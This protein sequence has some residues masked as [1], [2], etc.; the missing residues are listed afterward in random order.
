M[1]KINS[2]VFLTIIALPVLDIMTTFTTSLPLSVGAVVRTIG[3]GILF[4]YLFL[5]F[6]HRDSTFYFS[7]YLAAFM[8]ITLSFLINFVMKNPFLLIDEIQFSL[9]TVYYIIMI[10]L[11]IAI[12]EQQ[13]V[14]IDTILRA[15]N[16]ASV[17]AGVSYWI[18]IGT[19]TDISSYTFIKDGK[20]GWFYSANELSVIIVILLVLAVVSF[21]LKPNVL[22]IVA[23][24]FLLSMAPMIGTKTAFYGGLIIALS[25]IVFSVF[26]IKQ[27]M[28]LALIIVT[29]LF[30]VFLPKTPAITNE[31]ISNQ[32][33]EQINSTNKKDA[34]MEQLLSSRDTYVKNVKA[35]YTNALPI[36]KMFG[37]GYAGDYVKTPKTVE[38][39]FHEMFF[40]YG[41]IGGFFLL[42]PLLLLAKKIISFR[43]SVP[44]V[45]LLMTCGLCIGIAFFAG[46]VLFAP[47]VMSYIAILAIVTGLI[48]KKGRTA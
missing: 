17:I 1:K 19:K 30:I 15:T 16:I 14:R 25:Y 6:H 24:V 36:R 34:R 12:I 45:L 18:A 27:K 5:Y 20:S 8:M 29:V 35:D 28:N 31:T 2:I 39:D 47:S 13:N 21:Y 7:T 44:Y 48:L 41:V 22:A 9:K 26:T 46:H 43:L 3:M 32:M 11:A 23:Y 40:S 38:M 37:L 4:I 10:F 33:Y 42:L